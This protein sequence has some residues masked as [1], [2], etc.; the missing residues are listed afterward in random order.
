MGVTVCVGACGDI[1]R[2]ISHGEMVIQ[3]CDLVNKSELAEEA[4]HL[5]EEQT[6]PN[7]KNLP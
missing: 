2:G 1:G 5:V 6:K 4:E 7:L 3:K